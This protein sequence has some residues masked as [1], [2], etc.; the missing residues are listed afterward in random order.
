M[1]QEMG[2]LRIHGMHEIRAFGVRNE[3]I[4][5]KICKHSGGRET[6]L[7]QTLHGP[8]HETMDFALVLGKEGG[9]DIIP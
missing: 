8:C 5:Q 6:L 9:E 3:Q 4:F 7:R 2:K 1:P